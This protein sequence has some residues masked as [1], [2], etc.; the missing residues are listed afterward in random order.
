M[1]FFKHYP[2]KK[3]DLA[4]IEEHYKLGNYQELY[5]F[6]QE[7][8]K[9]GV[10]IPI[11]SSGSNGKKP[12]LYKTYRIQ[13]TIEN[14]ATLREEL[15]Y[16]IHPKLKNDYYLT[17]LTQYS[18]DREAIL[19]LSS[20]FQTK[21]S[22]L[23]HPTAINERSFQIWQQ[24]KFLLEEGNRLL[25]NVGLS[26]TDLNVY[27]TAEPLAYFS[28]CKETPQNILI[29]ENKDTFYSLRKYLIEGHKEILECRI[30]TLIY[31]GGKKGVK[32]FQHFHASVEPYLLHQDNRFYYFGD[33]DYEGI[34]I[35]ESLCAHFYCEPL[36]SAYEAMLQ[37]AANLPLPK[38]KEKQ[39]RHEQGVF[40]S[41]FNEVSAMKAIL[42]NEY[43][44]PQEILTMED[45]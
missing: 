35:Y 15:L 14:E 24:E 28:A 7:A 29:I 36:V 30:S 4:T 2:R 5:Y 33:L 39:N 31:G 13:V 43:Y 44:I 3:I 16:L 25:K 1:D 41:Y 40:F 27:E 38:T 32:G 20:F 19:K 10:I 11:K 12:A 42:E 23:E 34:I 26:M 22:D 45:F 21:S 9:A 18:N 17:H 8:L 37:K 6:I